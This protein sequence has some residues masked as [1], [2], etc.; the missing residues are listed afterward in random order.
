MKCDV[1]LLKSLVLVVI[2]YISIVSAVQRTVTDD[3]ERLNSGDNL[4]QREPLDIKECSSFLD[5]ACLRTNFVKGVLSISSGKSVKLFDGF[6]EIEKLHEQDI[7]TKK[8]KKGK[9]YKKED[10]K[11]S[12]ESSG[13]AIVEESFG[14]GILNFL[15]NYALNLNVLPGYMLHLTRGS[16]DNSIFNM[17][18][19]ENSN[20]K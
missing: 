4:Q 7:E 16:K 1:H 15:K 3:S 10:L 11:L 17:E 9:L 8:G 2:V 5:F 6:V 19:R 12:K 13:R 14:S 20:G 18:I